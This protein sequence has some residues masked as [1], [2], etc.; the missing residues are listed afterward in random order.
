MIC[1]STRTTTS[2]RWLMA[3]RRDSEFSSSLTSCSKSYRSIQGTAWRPFKLWA[4]HSSPK[5]TTLDCLSKQCLSSSFRSKETSRTY[6][7]GSSSTKYLNEHSQCKSN[8]SMGPWQRSRWANSW[9]NPTK[10]ME[11]KAFDRQFTLSLS[12]ASRGTALTSSKSS[13]KRARSSSKSTNKRPLLTKMSLITRQA[14]CT[15]TS[16]VTVWPPRNLIRAFS[17]T[18]GL[19]TTIFLSRKSPWLGTGRSQMGRSYTQ[20]SRFFKITLKNL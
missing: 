19:L 17:L 9:A 4:T 10:R 7:S 13:T 15:S 1:S 18:W 16:S 12:S 3:W 20:R 6:T 5:T 2:C 8:Q 14:S 11:S